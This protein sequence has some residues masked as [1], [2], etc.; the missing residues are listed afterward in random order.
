MCWKK[1]SSMACV[2]ELASVVYGV[3]QFPGSFANPK[4]CSLCYIHSK[5]PKHIYEAP[6]HMRVAELLRLP[7]VCEVEAKS[8]D[9]PRNA[10][11]SFGWGELPG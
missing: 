5:P 8:E 9:A 3:W 6:G 11:Q 10:S 4:S 1:E 7:T 2:I